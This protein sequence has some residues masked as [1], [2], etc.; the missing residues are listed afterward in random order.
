MTEE[1]S[2]QV[3]LEVVSDDPESLIV[4]RRELKLELKALTSALTVRM[5][6]ITLAAGAMEN[7]DI[8]TELT[9][10]ALLGL[11]GKAA[12]AFFRH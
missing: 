1:P 2:K 9:A 5:I 4:T 6:A 12:L 10:L 8:P 11:V 7:V 3:K